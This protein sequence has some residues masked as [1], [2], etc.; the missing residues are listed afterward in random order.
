MVGS[1][2]AVVEEVL[3]RLLDVVPAEGSQ[4]VHVGDEVSFVSLSAC[5]WWGE[6]EHFAIQSCAAFDQGRRLLLHGHQNGKHLPTQWCKRLLG[7]ECGLFLLAHFNYLL[8]HISAYKLDIYISLIA[9][10]VTSF[11]RSKTMSG[12]Y[13]LLGDVNAEMIL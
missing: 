1:I 2:G 12:I 8:L 7:L 10:S 4:D 13:V 11:N 9:I 5:C 3:K 6:G